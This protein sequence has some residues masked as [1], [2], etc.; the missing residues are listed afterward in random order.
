VFVSALVAVGLAVAGLVGTRLAVEKADRHN[1]LVLHTLDVIGDTEHLARLASEAQSALRGY[2]LL[3]DPA[4]L[5]RFT[6]ASRAFASEAIDLK[7]LVS[8]NPAQ[9]ARAEVIRE[10]FDAWHELAVSLSKRAGTI[11]EAARAQLRE[12]AGFMTKL[13]SEADVFVAHE[14]MLLTERRDASARAS[15]WMNLGVLIAIAAAVLLA[16]VTS[17]SVALRVARDAERIAG[18]A[19]AVAEGDLERR[20]D[21]TGKDE[22]ARASAA[23]NAMANNLH[24]RHEDEVALS[25]MRDMLH[26]SHSSEEAHGIL[27]RLAPQCLE[28]P[29]TRLYTINSSRNLLTPAVSWGDESLLAKHDDGFAP[30]SCWALRSGRPHVVRDDR[31][32]ACG[33]RADQTGPSVCQPLIAQGETVGLLYMTTDTRPRLAD[34]VGEMIGLTLANLRLREVLRNQAIRD[35]L[36]GLFNRRYLEETLSREVSRVRRKQ[37]ELA[38]IVLDVD[39]FKRFNDTYGHAGGDAML[40]EVGSVLNRS[41]R[42]SDIVCR[43]G[44]EEFVVVAPECSLAAAI[45][46]TEEMRQRVREIAINVEGRKVSGVTMSAGVAMFP[47]DGETPETLFQAADRAVYRSKNEGRDRITAA[48]TPA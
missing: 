17:F 35:P 15:W 21:V 3:A 34:D 1:T 37:T 29:A 42:D 25:R 18:A 45:Q 31:D 12:A 19:A 39:H 23:F 16:C 44:G 24:R 27:A 28:A 4:M 14:R 7:T 20:I 8:D 10:A 30:D 40:R 32:V 11:D 5:E 38:V 46:R 41:F 9:I 43:F 22:L 6:E 2:L 13:R 47:A 48:S 33:H 36:T 26:A